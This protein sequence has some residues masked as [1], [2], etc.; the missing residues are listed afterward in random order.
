MVILGFSR[1]EPAA[2][3]IISGIQ[4]ISRLPREPTRTP[5]GTPIMRKRLSQ[6]KVLQ[7]KLTLALG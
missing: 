6:Q 7:D 5:R 3:I 4:V 2:T 1:L